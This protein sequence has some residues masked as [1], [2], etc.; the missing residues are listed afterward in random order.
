[1]MN[2]RESG[3]YI[4]SKASHVKILDENIETVANQIL[5][6]ISTGEFEKMT[7]FADDV[8]PTGADEAA[9]DWFFIM[10]TINFSFWTDYDSS[11][12]FK[13]VF[14]G[15]AHT[16]AMAGAACL[17]RA[18]DRGIPIT[19]AK[20]MATID[21][22][23]MHEI[24]TDDDGTV[25]PMLYERMEA[26]Q[27]SGRVLLEKFDGT[28]YTCLKKANRNSQALLNLIIENLKS[29]QDFGEYKGQKVSFLKRAQIL[30]A[31]IYRNMG[32]T[33]P[34]ANFEDIESLTIFADYRVP[35]AMAFLNLLSYSAELKQ[36]L[37][38]KKLLDAGSEYEIEIR[39]CAIEACERISVVANKNLSENAP[40][41]TAMDIDT[42][43]WV[44]R[45]AHA[46]E[47]E[48]KVPY[49]RVRCI[50]Y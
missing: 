27:E 35:Q 46:E 12:P 4:A 34:L 19:S 5:L 22:K 45:R 28:F 50:Y 26:I 41:I 11:K 14:K 25:I 36:L 21:E 13:I 31:D 23:S 48:E 29:F 8:H 3:E 15:K 20:F 1:M 32:R 24:F 42:Y 10:N 6:S 43:F 38:S 49:H 39:G 2:P 9:A 44:Y 30:I 37:H 17:N 33:N 47:I 7:S 40:R 16:G 18:L